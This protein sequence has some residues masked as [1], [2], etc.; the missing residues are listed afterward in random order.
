MAEQPMMGQSPQ[1]MAEAPSAA[2]SAPKEEKAEAPAISVET[3]KSNY[4]GMD[5]DNK[6][7]IGQLMQDPITGILDSLTASTMFSD[8]AQSIGEASEPAAE[9]QAGIMGPG[10]E[11]T[12]PTPTPMAKGGLTAQ[13]HDMMKQGM[14]RQEILNQIG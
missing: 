9:P 14:S 11:M 8:F 13:V 7:A 5:D 6:S 3:M 2:P 12:T 10:P 1:A 4:D